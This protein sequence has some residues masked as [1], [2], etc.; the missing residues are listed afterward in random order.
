MLLDDPVFIRSKTWRLS[1]SHLT[2]PNFVNWGF[3][4]VVPDGVGVGYSIHPES[5]IFNI[6]ALK[7]T[8]WTLKL[9]DLLEEALLEM[10]GLIDKEREGEASE[11]T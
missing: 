8:N 2:H 1:T 3:G 4:Q 9:S 11:L 7:E 6:T 5:C 10:K